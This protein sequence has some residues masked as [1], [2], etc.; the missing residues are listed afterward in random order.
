MLLAAFGFWLMREPL[1]FSARGIFLVAG[2]LTLP[3]AVY[4][5]V[6]LPQA[7]IRFVV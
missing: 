2:L 4:S 3:V 5:F 1:D 6:R 7:T